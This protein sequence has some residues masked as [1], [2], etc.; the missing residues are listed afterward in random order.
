MFTPEQIKKVLVNKE[1]DICTLPVTIA[2]FITGEDSKAVF[3]KYYLDNW[4]YEF[5]FLETNKYLTNGDDDAEKFIE[6]IKKELAEK[7]GEVLVNYGYGYKKEEIA[8]EFDLTEEEVGDLYTKDMHEKIANTNKYSFQEVQ[9]MHRKFKF[10]FQSPP[11]YKYIDDVILPLIKERDE[12]KER[13]VKD[14]R[15]KKFRERRASKKAKMS[16]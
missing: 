7:I 12:K 3:Q 16:E 8:D 1:F 10:R 5:D 2:E 13:D 15:N 6:Q 11:L 14:M 9:N 4:T